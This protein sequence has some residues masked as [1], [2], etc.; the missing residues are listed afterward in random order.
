MTDWHVQCKT[1]KRSGV[2]LKRCSACCSVSYC[3]R[4]CQKHDW[5]DHKKICD[6]EQTGTASICL[7]RKGAS[8]NGDKMFNDQRQKGVEETESSVR[9]IQEALI[10]EN[11]VVSIHG[12]DCDVLYE[13]HCAH[14]KTFGATKSCSK[15]KIA[16]YCSKPCQRADW[17]EH[18]KNCQRV[19]YFFVTYQYI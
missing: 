12:R 17:P 6:K 16:F 13:H 9:Y 8:N 18:R 10:D 19:R 14:C 4:E 11:G 15:C 5:P 2:R 3:S 7:P 1:C